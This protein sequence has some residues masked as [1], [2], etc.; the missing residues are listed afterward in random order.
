MAEGEQEIRPRHL[1]VHRL[2]SLSWIERNFLRIGRR[3]DLMG[4]VWGRL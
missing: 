4:D 3:A 1:S 2:S